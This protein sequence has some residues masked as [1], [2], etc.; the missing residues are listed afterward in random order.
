MPEVNCSIC[1]REIHRM[2]FVVKKCKHFYCSKGCSNEGARRR[3]VGTHYAFK[4]TGYSVN[5]AHKWIESILGKPKKCDE[6]GTTAIR[7]YQWSNKNHTYK[8]N[9]KDWRRL[10]ISCHKK[11]DWKYL[12]SEEGRRTS[13]NNLKYVNV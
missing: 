10:C 12:Y 2:P 9:L 11:H 4:E 8:R 5:A 7:R 6:C 1:N 13:L 3:M